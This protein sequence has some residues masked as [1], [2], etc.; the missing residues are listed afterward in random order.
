VSIRASDVTEDNWLPHLIQ[1]RDN[2]TLERI[3]EAKETGATVLIRRSDGSMQPCQIVGWGYGCRQWDV[4]WG[5]GDDRRY[6]SVRL[7]NLLQ[8]NLNLDASVEP[9]A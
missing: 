2:G 5:E 7:E 1:C 9:T 4:A 6:K 8:W 3:S